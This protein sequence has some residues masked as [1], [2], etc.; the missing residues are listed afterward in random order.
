[1]DEMDFLQEGHRFEFAKPDDPSTELTYKG[2]VYNEMKGAMSSPVSQLW[3]T[4]TRHLFPTTTYHFNSG[5]DPEQITRLTYQDL[6]NFYKKHYHPSNAVFL[7]FG[8]IPASEHHDK[9]HRFAL[10]RFTRKDQKIEIH[11]EQ[12]YCAPI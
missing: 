1:L 11:D 6:K 2:V 9:M 4:F 12:R 7:T 3:Q 5:G 8:D 10:S